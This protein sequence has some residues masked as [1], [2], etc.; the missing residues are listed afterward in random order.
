MTEEPAGPARFAY[1]LDGDLRILAVD[2]DPIAR[3]FSAVYL[4]TP[5]VTV[6]TAACAE[7]ALEK[8]A[9]ARYDIALVDIDMPG[10]GGFELI[11]RIRSDARLADLPVI[12]VTGREDIASIDRA[13]HLGA[14]SFAVKPVN[15]RLM[16]Y[17][18]RYVLR[19]SR[20]AD[21]AAA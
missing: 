9:A 16:S 10:I 11:R 8:L 12:V 6:D 19:T 21:R 13:F 5:T 1:V 3:E 4:S 2:D 14:T 15:W 18:V 17:Q 20:R 7:E